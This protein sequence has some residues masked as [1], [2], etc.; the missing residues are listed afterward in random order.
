MKVYQRVLNFLL[1][2]S[3]PFLT[4]FKLVHLGKPFVHC[5]I[6]GVQTVADR[7]YLNKKLATVFLVHFKCRNPSSFYSSL[8]QELS[9]AI[10]TMVGNCNIIFN[11]PKLPPP[12]V[13]KMPRSLEPAFSTSINPSLPP[14]SAAGVSTT[15]PCS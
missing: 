2:P 1:K 4:A 6:L 14:S 15:R 7:N 13:V 11:R 10:L 8:S 3:P 9:E 5:D 12:G